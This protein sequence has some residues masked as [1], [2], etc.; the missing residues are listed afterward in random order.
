MSRTTN[1]TLP[2]IKYGGGSFT[3]PKSK[4]IATGQHEGTTAITLIDQ[5]EPIKILG[6][7]DEFWSDY[8]ASRSL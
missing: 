4:L 5:D 3:F 7:V 2:V 8:H 1:S 6:S